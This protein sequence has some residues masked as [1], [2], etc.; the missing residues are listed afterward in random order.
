[1]MFMEII[2]STPSPTPL[3]SRER[4]L[5]KTPKQSLEA[6]LDLNDRIFGRTLFTQL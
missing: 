3:P 6:F 1:M 2:Y 5:M 4:E